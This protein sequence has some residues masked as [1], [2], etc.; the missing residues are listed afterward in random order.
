MATLTDSTPKSLFEEERSMDWILP[1]INVLHFTYKNISRSS[2]AEPPI[3]RSPFRSARRCLS[4]SFRI[5]LAL[6]MKILIMMH[7][8]MEIE[9]KHGLL[10]FEDDFFMIS[11]ISQETTQLYTFV[12]DELMLNID[13][14]LN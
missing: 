10:P 9:S 8:Q 13:M 1:I 5:Y 4:Q 11:T 12:F 14:I 7:F 2:R 6:L 3:P